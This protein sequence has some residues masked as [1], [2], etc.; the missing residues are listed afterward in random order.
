MEQTLGHRI[1]ENRKRLKLT[2]EQ[3]AEQL[4][5]TAQA[6]SKWENDQS[7]PDI[8]MLPKLAEIFGITTDALLG[9]ENTYVHQ[10]EVVEESEPKSEGVHIE[11]GNWEFH[12]DSGRK[13]SLVFALFVLLVGG[14]TFASRLLSWDASF[15]EIL[16]PSALL[17]FGI[18]GLLDHFSFF[19][20]GCSLFGAY[21]L[22]SNLGVGIPKFSSDLLFPIAVV[23]FGLS[24][25]VDALRKPK[26]PV[27][28]V[29]HK[30]DSKK[31]TSDFSVENEEFSA[32]LTFGEA[33]HGV[34]LPR[35][36]SG[37]AEC[38]FGEMTIDL[39]GC[40]T[41]APNCRVDA[42]CT[43][44]EMTLLVPSKYRVETESHSSN[45][46]G[47]FEV[48]GHPDPEP[49][50]VLHLETA[51]RFGEITLRYV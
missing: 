48:Q 15:W 46:F 42:T 27:F 31:T 14:L 23:L 35:L 20:L 3:L 37:T 30:G 28:K 34:Y 41:L 10:A 7:C 21:F 6:V 2:Q 29:T 16:W 11:K 39:S 50:D 44:G 24:L 40:E 18:K 33:K 19:P 25:L 49:Q 47:S 43:F 26:K 38:T 36:S 1:M 5:V 9:R 51:I 32:V 13:G 12:W 17:V 8:T 45:A 4:G 22:L